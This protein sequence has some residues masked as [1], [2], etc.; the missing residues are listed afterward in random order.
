MKLRLLASKSDKGNLCDVME[1]VIS[2]KSKFYDL[3]RS[4]RLDTC[5][6]KA[7]CDEHPNESDLGRALQDVLLLWLDQKY[8]AKKHGRPTWRMLVTAVDKETGG[9]N[10]ELAKKIADQHPAG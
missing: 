10:H 4:L 9:N 8:D 3:G 6:L 2:I 7:I 5:D 1:E